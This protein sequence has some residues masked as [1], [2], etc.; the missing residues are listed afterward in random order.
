MTTMSQ[1]ETIS[2]MTTA[3]EQQYDEQLRVAQERFTRD[4]H[5][6]LTHLQHQYDDVDDDVNRVRL[7]AYIHKIS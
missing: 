5:K 4:S 3:E 1:Q 7:Y 2:M 6:K